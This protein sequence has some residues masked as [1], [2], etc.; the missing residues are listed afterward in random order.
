[1]IFLKIDIKIISLSRLSEFGPNILTADNG[2]NLNNISDDTVIDT[3]NPGN[4]SS[5]AF[6]NIINGWIHKWFFCYQ[7]EL[8]KEGSVI[9]IGLFD[10]EFCSAIHPNAIKI[11]FSVRRKF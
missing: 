4:T 2:H 9:F 1:M 3:I 7:I 10:T 8:M 11:V 6:A 5:I